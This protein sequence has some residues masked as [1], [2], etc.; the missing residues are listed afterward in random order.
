M[1]TW[2]GTLPTAPLVQGYQE[3]APELTIRT[4][5]DQGPDKVRKRTTA[6]V[7]QFQAI[8]Q[9]TT[10]QV[11]TFETFY[12]TTTNGGADQF[13]FDHP[14]TGSTE[15]KFRFVGT[16]VYTSTGNGF[17]VAVGLELLP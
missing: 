4:Q 14:R 17:R 3:I 1:A 5:M 15:T 12:E 16:P 6:G 2:P 8:F 10:A 9:M 11:A 7:R 13:T